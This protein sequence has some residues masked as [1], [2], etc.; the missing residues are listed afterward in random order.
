MKLFEVV[1]DFLMGASEGEF[2]ELSGCEPA[3]GDVVGWSCESSPP[4]FQC[5]SVAG[6]GV[7]DG[8]EW[9]CGN[10]AKV[11]PLAGRVSPLRAIPDYLSCGAHRVTS[12]TA[13]RA[14][15]RVREFPQVC[16][17]DAGWALVDEES[18]VVLDDESDE[19][20]RGGGC[21]FAEIGDS[22]P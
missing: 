3:T 9:F 6:D 18:A 15:F 7:L 21:A 8:A 4:G 19:A 16:I 12:P 17:D 1:E 13:V 22:V 20:A 10:N 5:D 14:H 2:L 11:S